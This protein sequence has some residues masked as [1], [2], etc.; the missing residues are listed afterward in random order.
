MRLRR[1]YHFEYSDTGDNRRN[2]HV[3]LLGSEL[4]ML[5]L[6]H[7]HR[8]GLRLVSPTGEEPNRHFPHL[9]S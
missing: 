5:H 2:G 6:P 1:V 3:T 4:V 8:S 7:T 9:P